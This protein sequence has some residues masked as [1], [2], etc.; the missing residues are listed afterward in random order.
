MGARIVLLNGVGSAGKSSIARALQAIATAP[1]L[2]VQMDSFL[3]ML[4]AA[5]L[6][7]PDGLV[8]TPRET[9]E[10]PE[11]AISGGP[12]LARVMHGMRL[13][14]AALAAAGN[15]LIVDDVMFGEQAAEY[16]RLLAG[17]DVM[18]VGILAP[19]DVLEARE[20]ARGD[21]MPGLARWQFPR[22]HAGRRYDLELDSSTMPPEDCA[23]RIAARFRL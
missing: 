17:F 18:H 19:L 16:D 20:Q 4:P 7:H 11:V 2:H 21:R 6:N 23:R 8:F 3:D 13:S 9:P 15:N 12:V 1:F 5:Y 10:G 22:V 14:I